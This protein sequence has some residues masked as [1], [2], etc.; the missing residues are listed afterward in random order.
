MRNLIVGIICFAGIGAMTVNL[1]IAQSGKQGTSQKK[2]GGKN[3]QKGKG[4]QG[5]QDAGQMAT[6]MIKDYDRNGDKSL[7][8]QELTIALQKMREERSSRQ[9]DGSG[10]KGRG[11]AGKGGKGGPGK[12]GRG[13]KGKG[14]RGKGK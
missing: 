2:S 12:G 4:G 6:R 5:K 7:N 13:G 1:A 9:Q 14:G 8:V 3:G 11:G 10:G